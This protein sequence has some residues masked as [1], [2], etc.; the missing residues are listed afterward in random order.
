MSFWLGPLDARGW[1]AAAAM[2]RW[3]KKSASFD[4][5]CTARFGAMH[6][7]VVRGDH[8]DWL[9]SPR[10]RL[11]YVIVLDQLSRNIHRDRPA[12]FAADDRAL[13]VARAGV[14]AGVDDEL[15][16]HER[17]FLYMPFM[18]AEDEAAQTRSVALFR[19]LGVAFPD[20]VDAA[21]V[22]VDFAERHR[23]IVVRFGRFPHRNRILGRESNDEERAFLEQPG[24]R[25]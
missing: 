17:Y 6:A 7:A 13:A 22:A 4:A 5:L 10:G 23:E 21:A 2:G 16:F 8:D 12:M 20:L 3:W 9:A 14:D 18:H 11:G 15:G 25:F 24:S 19:G 1:A